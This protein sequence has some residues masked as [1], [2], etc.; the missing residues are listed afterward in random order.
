MVD[1]LID[2][3]IEALSIGGFKD[4]GALLDYIFETVVP[5]GASCCG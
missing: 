2:K 5:V 4:F 1:T 3:A